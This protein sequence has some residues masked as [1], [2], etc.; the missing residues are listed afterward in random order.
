MTKSLDL[1]Q[2]LAEASNRL[3]L[4]GN[5]I[6]SLR[7]EINQLK[8]ALDDARSKI[9]PQLQYDESEEWMTRFN[10][11][12]L[13]HRRDIENYEN[14]LARKDQIILELRDRINTLLATPP[15]V[16]QLPAANMTHSFSNRGRRRITADDRDELIG[17]LRST[18][19]DQET[20]IESLRRRP[21]AV[22]YVHESP[23]IVRVTE[24]TPK[25]IRYEKDE[26]LIRRNAELAAEL[27]HSLVGFPTH[28]ER[29]TECQVGAQ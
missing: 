11:L 14:E 28:P 2:T 15:Q 27:E 17:K 8:K 6:T 4:K 18:I 29:R 19:A 5:E 3:K 1:E 22:D 16:V 23:Q 24:A 10:E 9:K 12:Q 26:Y 13:R 25:E 20:E 7:D 21:T